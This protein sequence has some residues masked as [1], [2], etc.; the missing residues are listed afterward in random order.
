VRDPETLA[1]TGLNGLY[2]IGEG[3]GYTGGIVS[4]AL[5]GMGAVERYLSAEDA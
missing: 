3:S 4:S 1:S 2:P 5:D